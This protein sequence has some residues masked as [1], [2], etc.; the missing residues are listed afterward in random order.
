MSALAHAVKEMPMLPQAIF[1]TWRK[2]EDEAGVR[3]LLV[4]N[5]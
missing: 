2:N 3:R 5:R 1:P 4:P